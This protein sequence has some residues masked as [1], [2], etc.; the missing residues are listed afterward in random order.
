MCL[1]LT[2]DAAR[3]LATGRSGAGQPQDARHLYLVRFSALPHAFLAWPPVVRSESACASHVVRRAL[4]QAKEG[5]IEDGSPAW[6]QM[7]PGKQPH[8]QWLAGMH[9]STLAC[10]SCLCPSNV[11]G[12]MTHAA[13]MLSSRSVPT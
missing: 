7:S 8:A 10:G 1:A 6:A 12:E 2:Q 4:L 3:S 5:A 13:A 11:P 9:A